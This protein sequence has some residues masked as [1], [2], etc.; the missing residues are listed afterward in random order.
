M[1]RKISIL[2]AGPGG[3][4][5]AVRAAQNGAQVTV[6][7]KSKVGGTCLNWGCIPSKIMKTTA[8]L[9]ENLQRAHAFGI[10]SS[11]ELTV[12]M[13]ALMARKKKVLQTQAKGIES[14]LAHHNI[15]LV[16]GDGHIDRQGLLC[17]TQADGDVKKVSWDQLI[18][19]TGTE[20][21]NIP[22]FPFDG[23]HIISSN[24]ALCL[25]RVPQSVVIVGGGVIGCE[26]AC[27]LS[28]LGSQ[29]TIV[30]A[31]DRLLPLPSV[32]EACSKILMREMKKRKIK[33]IV[34]H[35]VTSVDRRQNRL[36]IT[37]GPSPVTGNLKKYNKQLT[38]LEADKILV[39]IGR[40][41]NTT[42]IG[43]QNIDVKV[44]QR[45]WIVVDEKMQTN[46]A[47]VYAIGDVIDGPM[48]AHKAEE[49]GVAAVERIAGVAG[50]VNY[51][52]IPNVVYTHP[53]VASVGQ[54]E[55]Q[56]KK[57]GVPYR[58]GNF[59]FGANGRAL[60]MNEPAG[61]V[62]VLAHRETDRVL[63][64]H[65][66]GTQASSLIAESTVFVS[67][68]L[69]PRDRAC[70]GTP[71][72][73]PDRPRGF[74]RVFLGHAALRARKTASTSA[75]ASGTGVPGPKIAATPASR[76]KS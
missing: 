76:R 66:V 15:D 43:L 17:I 53:E 35:T 32:D 37:I 40:S 61:F 59:R 41:P 68:T 18:I 28:A 55:E 69:D 9:M 25:E 22:A 11:G 47:N 70:H 7:E 12:D 60:A 29:V 13:P 20:P 3:Y 51:Q 75:A 30:E 56:L 8:E 19:S 42:G 74:A 34:N 67:R 36:S 49:E 71:I 45:G 52:T 14:L 4:V 58:K 72:P 5:A 46:V 39:C 23:Q 27:I 26:F 65:V 33:F 16:S 64:V 31:L 2:G 21:Q 10:R 54:T 57:D 62:K 24:E 1:C 6:V 73:G 48:L 50:H 63:G 38:T 44:D